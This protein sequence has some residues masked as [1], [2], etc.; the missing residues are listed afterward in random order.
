MKSY[1]PRQ[2]E[3]KIKPYL[4]REEVIAITGPRQVG[5]TTLVKKLQEELSQNNKVEYLTFENRE[6]R[7]LFKDGQDFKQK[8]QDYDIVIIDEF[9]YA[10]NG[11]KKLKFLY[12]TTDIKFIITGSSS[13]DLIFSTGEYMVGRM[14]TFRLSPFSFREFLLAENSGLADRLNSRIEAPLESFDPSQVYGDK[15]SEDLLDNFETYLVYGGYP[16]VVKAPKKQKKRILKDLFNMYLTKEIN[17]LLQLANDDQLVKLAESLSVQIGGLMR[18]NNLS[19][20]T[21]LKYKKLKEYINILE[22]TYIVNTIRPFF[23][24]RQ[25]EIVKNPIAYFVDLGLRNYLIDNFQQTDYRRDIGALVENFVL[26]RLKDKFDVGLKNIKY[27][28]TKA[29]AEVDFVVKTE[30]EQI[31]FEVKYRNDPTPGKSFYSFLREYSPSKGYV[32][33]KNKSKVIEEEGAKIYF[34][35][36]YY[37]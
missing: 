11:G 31:P 18:Y 7:K 2:L 29:G 24:N 35:P 20:L 19:E 13:L 23:T 33:T 9:Q 12:D 25:K 10:D 30:G 15:I 36:V 1:I 28:R 3:Q 22:K 6:Q 5:K 34:I 27:W 16:E 8:Y 26:A 32:L 14:L 21:G 17:N 37:L 4:D